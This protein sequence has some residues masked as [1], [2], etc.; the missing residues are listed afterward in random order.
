MKPGKE[1][2]DKNQQANFRAKQNLHSHKTRICVWWSMEQIIDYK[3]KLKST[4]LTA[5]AVHYKR[6]NLK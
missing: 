2:T 1:N 4:T 6:L 5:A 3:S